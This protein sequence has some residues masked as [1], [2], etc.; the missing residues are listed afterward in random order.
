V[1]QK[2]VIFAVVNCLKASA[3]SGCQSCTLIWNALSLFRTSWSEQDLQ[4]AVELQVCPGQPL[5]VLFRPRYGLGMYLDL[6]TSAGKVR[7]FLALLCN[8]MSFLVS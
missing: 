4:D 8:L 5:L 7:G 3:E 2:A 1:G 6:C